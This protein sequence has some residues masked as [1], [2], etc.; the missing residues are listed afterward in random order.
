MTWH[1]PYGATA[2]R[3]PD[4]AI[5][6]RLHWKPRVA[7]ASSGLKKAALSQVNRE[8]GL[9]NSWSHPLLAYRPSQIAGSGRKTTIEAAGIRRRL[10]SGRRRNLLPFGSDGPAAVA[11]PGRRP[12]AGP[13]ARPNRSH[14]E[15]TVSSSD[16][17]GSPAQTGSTH[18]ET[19]RA[20]RAPTCPDTG[21]RSSAAGLSRSRRE[22][23]GRSRL[24]GN[25][26]PGCAS[27][28]AGRSHH[29]GARDECAT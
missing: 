12:S 17:G 5:R 14:R 3:G 7:A 11:V 29:R 27:G 23:E 6:P 8:R 15:V 20:R 19:Q 1:D 24:Q 28:K 22:H 18:P 13:A 21:E 10:S 4:G 2:R 16:L 25:G 9:G 26:L